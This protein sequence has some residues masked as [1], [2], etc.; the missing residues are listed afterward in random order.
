MMVDEFKLNDDTM[1]DLRRIA[2]SPGEFEWR[3]ELLAKLERYNQE[4]DLFV[5]EAVRELKRLDKVKLDL[6]EVTKWVRIELDE[7]LKPAHSVLLGAKKTGLWL[8]ERI[9]LIGFT[10]LAIKLGLKT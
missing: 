2:Q 1:R 5:R 7:R 10:Y 6:T 3:V 4:H 9:A 8:I